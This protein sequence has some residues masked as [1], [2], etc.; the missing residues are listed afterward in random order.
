MR[1]CVSVFMKI[2]TRCMFVCRCGNSKYCFV[3]WSFLLFEN[4]K[5]NCFSNESCSVIFKEIYGKD[6]EISTSRFLCF[7]SSAR[8]WK[9]SYKSRLSVVVKGW[10]MCKHQS[11]VFDFSLTLEIMQSIKN[12]LEFIADLTQSVTQFRCACS[13]ICEQL[14]ASRNFSITQR[15]HY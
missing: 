2:P 3:S 10:I 11:T 4:S 15:K 8:L 13:S 9:S 14:F 5:E 6:Y 7:S 12:R 1:K